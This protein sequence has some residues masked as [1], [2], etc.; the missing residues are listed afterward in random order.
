M[1]NHHITIHMIH[2]PRL[3]Q[4]STSLHPTVAPRGPGAVAPRRAVPCFRGLRGFAAARL[5]ARAG[6]Q[7]AKLLGQPGAPVENPSS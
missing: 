6:A 1:I 3:T 4:I 2:D 5:K 7:R